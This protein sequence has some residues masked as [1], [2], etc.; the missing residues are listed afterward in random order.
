MRMIGGAINKAQRIVHASRAA[1]FPLA[2]KRIGGILVA[3]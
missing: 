3:W 1:H 2:A